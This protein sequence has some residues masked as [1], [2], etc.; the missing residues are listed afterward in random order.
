MKK[1]AVSSPIRNLLLKT[2]KCF[3]LQDPVSV[4]GTPSVV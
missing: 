1:S 4:T 3:K 2:F